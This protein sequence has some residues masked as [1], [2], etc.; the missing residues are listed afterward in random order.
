MLLHVGQ[1]TE[2]TFFFAAPECDAN[3]AARFQVESRQNADGFEHHRGADA[4]VGCTGRVMPGIVVAAE[5]DDFVFFVRARNFADGVVRGCTLRIFLVL[6]VDAQGDRHAVVH[7]P[8]NAA[9]VVVAHHERRHG[10]SPV[11][12][13]VL[14]GDDDAVRAAGVVHANECAVVH[15]ELIDLPRDLLAVQLPFRKFLWFG[16]PERARIL[17]I[18]TRLPFVLGTAHGRG[19]HV[20]GDFHMLPYEDDR[21]ADFVFHRIQIGVEFGLCW[22]FRF[23]RFR[24]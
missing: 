1:R 7:D 6:D 8:G 10:A 9:V 2:Q 14:L 24:S 17:R 16:K 23:S 13:A 3:R 20:L 21:A 22:L 4:V 5:H 19:I 11:V 15:Q 18:E 12:S